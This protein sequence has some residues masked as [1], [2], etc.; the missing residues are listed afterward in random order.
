MPS[1]DV[2]RSNFHRAVTGLTAMASWLLAVSLFAGYARASQE[3]L[4]EEGI[5]LGLGGWVFGILA[6]ILVA[7]LLP[8]N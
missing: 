7:R 6:L 4:E 5:L 2:T 8:R 3:S 1:D